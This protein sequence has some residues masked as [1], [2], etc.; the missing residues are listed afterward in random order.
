MT[1]CPIEDFLT[2]VPHPHRVRIMPLLRAPIG[3]GLHGELL[4]ERISPRM[5]LSGLTCRKYEINIPMF[6]V[7]HA[8]CLS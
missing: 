1:F 4:E 2:L 3:Y 7:K 8:F 5:C 6:H